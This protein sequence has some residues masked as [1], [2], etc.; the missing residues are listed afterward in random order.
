ML[1]S[2]WALSVKDFVC[3]QGR[4]VVLLWKCQSRLVCCAT[5]GLDCCVQSL[6]LLLVKV[7]DLDPVCGLVFGQFV[8]VVR[9]AVP[10]MGVLA[11]HCCF[12]FRVRRRPV[13]CLLPLLSVGCSG[14]WCFHMAFG[15]MSRTVATFV[16][17]A[18]FRC[19]FLLC[20]SCVLEALVAVWRVALPTCGVLEALSFP[21]LGHL[22]LADAL[23]LYCYRC[24]VAALP[25]LGSPIGVFLVGLV[26]SVPVE[27]PTSACVLCAIVVCR[28]SCRMSGRSEWLSGCRGVPDGRVLVAMWA[29]VALRLVTRRPAP[30]RSEGQRLK[31]LSA[32]PSPSLAFLPSLLSEEGKVSLFPLRRWE[33]GGAAAARAEHWRAVVERGGGGRGIVKAPFWVGSSFSV[34]MLVPFLIV[35][36]G[37]P[38]CSIPAVCFPADVTTAERVATSE[39]ASPRSGMTLSRLALPIVMGFP[40]GPSGGNATAVPFVPALANGPS[41]GFRK[42]CR[43]CLCL[44]DLSWLQASCAVS[45]GGCHSSSL[46]P[47]ARHLRAYPR[48]RLLPLPG[49]PS[50]ARLC[51]RKLLRAAGVLKLAS[52]PHCLALR[53]LRSRVGRQES[54]AGVLEP[55]LASLGF[56]ALVSWAVLSGFRSA[57]SLGVSCADTRL[58]FLYPFLGAVHGGTGGGWSLTSWSGQGPV[59]F[60]GPQL[61]WRS[62]VAVLVL[63]SL[64]VAPVFFA[65]ACVD[66]AGSA[67]VVFG[68]TRV[69][70]EAFLYFRCFVVLCSRLTPLLSSGRDSLS[71]EFVVGR[72]W[73]RL[74]RRALPAV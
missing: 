11:L 7:V 67:G 1:Q 71:Q 31:A 59:L 21:P 58:L 64:V 29:A 24:G 26:R 36:W 34:E 18:S 52:P 16:A 12:L 46:S 13:V 74:V 37:T 27:L 9:M 38:G 35:V 51:Q 61:G 54:T 70:V 25:R 28:V 50:P 41:G 23:W 63:W 5:F 44:L 22:V 43:A 6:C 30:S 55:C 17:K 3:P 49:T 33:L 62:E 57:G 72:S 32:L 39:K 2:A 42:G 68:L 45:V 20:I 40:L 60:V 66:S 56:V 8:V 4:E 15:A 48:D 65:S 73:W 10:P 53:W 69:V 14:W 19:V 47:G